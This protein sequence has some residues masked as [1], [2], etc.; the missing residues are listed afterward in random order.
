M[1]IFKNEEDRLDFG[2]DVEMHED[3]LYALHP[4]YG[5]I[6]TRMLRKKVDGVWTKRK[7][8]LTDADMQE[9]LDRKARASKRIREEL[10]GFGVN[11]GML[12]N[13]T[14]DML[15]SFVLGITYIK[16]EDV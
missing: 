11:K 12:M 4:K 15:Y 13:F 8:D 2:M 14:D 1:N 7:I 5:T 6:R 9:L 3:G 10:V 16:R